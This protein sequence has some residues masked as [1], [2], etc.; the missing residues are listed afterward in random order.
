MLPRWVRFLIIPVFTAHAMQHISPF[1]CSGLFSSHFAMT[2]R[3]RINPPFPFYTQMLI[4]MSDI[5]VTT[6]SA[7]GQAKM[8]LVG[9]EGRNVCGESEQFS[10]HDSF[11]H[12][13]TIFS[14]FSQPWPS[15][16]TEHTL[17]WHNLHAWPCSSR[18]RHIS[19]FQHTC[20][21]LIFLSLR[22][23][24]S[25]YSLCR[26]RKTRSAVGV[27]WEDDCLP[28]WHQNKQ[29]SPCANRTPYSLCFS[30]SLT[31]YSLFPAV[32]RDEKR[33]TCIPYTH[34]QLLRNYWV[35]WGVNPSPSITCTYIRKHAT[36]HNLLWK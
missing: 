20:K 1:S 24:S 8:T 32:P 7:T 27:M 11:R 36:T 30:L 14:C 2:V 29:C 31:E 33:V 10:C 18:T 12:T 6:H 13:D 21:L 23:N 17:K 28:R 19:L 5:T 26:G 35:T 3:V 25:V 34:H 9:N 4:F 16:V 15:L 22:W